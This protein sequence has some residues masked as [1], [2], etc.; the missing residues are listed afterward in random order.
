M[1]DE[2]ESKP[3]K[4]APTPRNQGRKK[5][6]EGKWDA[7]TALTPQ[8]E[9]FCQ[10]YANCGIASQ[11]AREAGYSDWQKEGSTMRKNPRIMQRI[12]ELMEIRDKAL[13][14]ATAKAFS[15]PLEAVQERRERIL[16]KM[17]E[18]AERAFADN[19]YGHAINALKLLGQQEG[20]FNPI[21]QTQSV[22]VNVSAKSALENLPPQHISA[23]L[24]AVKSIRRISSGIVAEPLPNAGE[25]APKALIEGTVE[26]SSD[27]DA[28]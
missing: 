16:S 1:S 9:A 20:L 13:A 23:L 22:N 25:D 21:L 6:G 4:S 18:V 19:E 3:K 7:I 28:A 10:A 5:A 12:T 27:D 14:K 8:Q 17:E 2:T 24:D 15:R 11:A 26:P